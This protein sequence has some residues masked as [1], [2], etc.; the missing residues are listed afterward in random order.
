MNT[1]LFKRAGHLLTRWVTVSL[2][3]TLLQGA[4][5]N[6]TIFETTVLKFLNLVYIIVDVLRR[7]HQV[8]CLWA[9]CGKARNTNIELIMVTV[10]VRHISYFIR[11]V[12]MQ[13]IDH[14]QIQSHIA[15]CRKLSIHRVLLNLAELTR[16]RNVC[17]EGPRVGY[18]NSPSY[19]FTHKWITVWSIN[20]LAIFKVCLA[21]KW[22]G[23]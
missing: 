19:L 14:F 11:S 17:I 1:T 2:W 21:L 6:G 3:K 8:F 5:E 10:V 18:D 4:G 13:E 22:V 20:I 12:H 9:K 15:S 16:R 23:D 7:Q